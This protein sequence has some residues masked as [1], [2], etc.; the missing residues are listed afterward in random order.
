MYKK[1]RLN[2]EDPFA[3]LKKDIAAF[4]TLGEIML[5]GDFNAR[6]TNN[7]TINLKESYKESKDLVWLEEGA[8]KWERSW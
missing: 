4:S 6:T 3:T 5:I 1:H 7:Q 8:Q 2:R